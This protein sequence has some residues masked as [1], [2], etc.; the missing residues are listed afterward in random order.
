MVLEE[1]FIGG[2]FVA[3]LVTALACLTFLVYVTLLERHLL[4]ANAQRTVSSPVPAPRAAAAAGWQRTP[5]SSA[6][7]EGRG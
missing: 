7:P 1:I 4:R 3:A 2:V 5:R 6:L